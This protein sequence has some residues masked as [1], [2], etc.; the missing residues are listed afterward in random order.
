[1]ETK[2]KE[3]F[4]IEN[5][6]EAL[7]VLAGEIENLAEK[8]ELPVPLTMNLNLVLE[9]AVSNVIFYAF[10]DHQKHLIQI[11]LAL[12][13]KI[14][15]VEIVDDGIPFDPLSQKLPD[16]TL[17]VEERPIGG[18]GILLILKIMDQVSYSRQN[19]QNRLTL[20]KNI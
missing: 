12:E 20:V 1:M 5:R 16:I 14:L 7:S 19:N 18:L 17:P 9:E 3:V 10:N 2:M 15:T 4:E 8:W 6:I 11:S 13:N